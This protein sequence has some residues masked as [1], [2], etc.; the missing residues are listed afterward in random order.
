M[1]RSLGPNTRTRLFAVACIRSCSSQKLCW[2]YKVF[3][4]VWVFLGVFKKMDV[5]LVYTVWI[6][7]GFA[8]KNY[9]HFMNK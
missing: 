2:L 7:G 1:W 5:L 8:G 9:D 6:C 3:I 4:C